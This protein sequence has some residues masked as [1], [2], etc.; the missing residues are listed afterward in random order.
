MNKGGSRRTT[1]VACTALGC[2]ALLFSSAQAL[3]QK[4]AKKPP[5]LGAVVT[6][7]ATVQGA[8][9]NS[10]VTAT[11]SCPGKR[12]AFGGGFST[13]P[14]NFPASTMIPVSSQRSGQRSW[15]VTGW[16]FAG[17]TTIT[18]YVYCRKASKI[19]EVAASAPL[20][21]QV[22][23]A[24]TASAQ[25]PKKR[26]LISGGFTSAFGTLGSETAVTYASSVANRAW[27]V[28]AINNDATPRNITAYAYCAKKAEVATRIVSGQNTAVI[29]SN[30]AVSATSQPCT[31]KRRL[32][33][34]GFAVSP[35]PAGGGII[36]VVT[37]NR[38]NGG[39][40][41]TTVSNA[42]GSPTSTTATAQGACTS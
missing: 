30:S 42:S 34:G 24:G 27:T 12:R 32:S 28:S 21:G 6:R 18:V 15:T 4:K 33:G 11:A 25:C 10:R 38:L 22:F 5:K 2:S 31:G 39:A 20:P 8:S 36:P 40:W 19:T 9:P 1:V 29:S 13:S 26:R 37:E 3:A 14:S 17:S 7:T 41:L 16:S 23:G 35:R